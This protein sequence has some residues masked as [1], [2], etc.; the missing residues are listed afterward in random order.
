MDSMIDGIKS[1]QHT[2]F[3]EYKE[4]F[5]KLAK[6]QNPE[7]LM[8]TCSDSRID[9]NLLT[10]TKPG[11]LF[12]I[13]NAGNIIPPYGTG[14]GEEATIEYA[15]RVLGVRNIV[16][17]GHT[18]CGAMTAL[19][20]PENLSKLPS[21]KSWLNL[22]KTALKPLEHLPPE[23]DEHAR[24]RAVIDENVLVQLKNLKT[25]PAIRDGLRDGKVH[26]L[27]AVYAFE[28]GEFFLHSPKKGK[29]VTLHEVSTEELWPDSENP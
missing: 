26:L 20:K 12:L 22:A 15:I 11:E 18:D 24:L 8:I 3:P 25:H 9:P 19:I 7:V 1:F 28:S 27:G 17:C 13:R 4:L 6:G 16:V 2:V 29:F 23:A 10:Q 5:W 21:V 14:G